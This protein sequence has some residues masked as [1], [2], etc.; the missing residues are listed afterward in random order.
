MAIYER[1]SGTTIELADTPEMRA[2][3][4]AQ[5]WIKKRNTGNITPELDGENTDGNSGD[6]GQADTE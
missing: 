1:P 3:G 2:F 6:T 5:G 4:K